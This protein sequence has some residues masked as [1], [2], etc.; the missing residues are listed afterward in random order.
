MLNLKKGSVEWK[1][2][3]A[4]ILHHAETMTNEPMPQEAIDAYVEITREQPPQPSE[5]ETFESIVTLLDKGLLMVWT[6]G[7]MS[8]INSVVELKKEGLV[9]EGYSPKLNQY[10]KLFAG[11][12]QRLKKSFKH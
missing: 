1:I 9:P 8:A 11:E 10:G 6:D 7:K 4:I 3:G 12:Y 5:E 2:V